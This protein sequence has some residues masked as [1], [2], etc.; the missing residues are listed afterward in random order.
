MRLWELG[1]RRAGRVRVW[2]VTWV[3]SAMELLGS[4]TAIS[5][6]IDQT[7]TIGKWPS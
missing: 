4:K 6:F 2:F 7:A 5:H 1:N 3:K